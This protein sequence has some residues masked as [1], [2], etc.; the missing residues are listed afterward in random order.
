M[1]AGF[2]TPGY[3]SGLYLKLFSVLSLKFFSWFYETCIFV[4]YIVA[5]NFSM[6]LPNFLVNWNICLW[7]I[8]T[9]HHDVCEHLSVIAMLKKSKSRFE[10]WSCIILELGSID[11]ALG[12][13][14]STFTVNLSA[15]NILNS[16]SKI[17][18]LQCC[19]LSC[20]SIP[21]RFL[22][23]PPLWEIIF[24]GVE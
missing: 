8:T 18:S 12:Y 13:Y 11:L 20:S 16:K 4:C 7:Q 5:N 17:I 10:I 23:N 15:Y 3:T 6:E 21:G 2:N 9:S 1:E 14:L 22:S 19:C 24:A